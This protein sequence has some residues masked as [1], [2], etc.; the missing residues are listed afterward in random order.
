MKHQKIKGSFF[1]TGNA[2]RNPQF[3]PVI[4]QILDDGHYLGGH[5]DGHLL[6]ATWEDR[7]S[8]VSTDSLLIDLKRNQQALADWGVSKAQATYYLP[9]YEWYNDEQVK[10]IDLFGWKAINFTSGLR[11]A[12]DYTT[13]NMKGYMS[14]QALLDH[15][16]DYEQAHTLNGAIVLIHPGTVEERTDKLYL[17]LDELIEGLRAK[18][19][20]FERLD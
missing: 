12:A 11:V 6:Y 4:Q 16:H 14:S 18:G 5:S 10:D 20:R 19:Y 15:L 1:L 8:L 9:P 7:S 13:P 3:K 17:R 2:L